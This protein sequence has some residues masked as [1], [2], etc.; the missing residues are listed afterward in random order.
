MPFYENEEDYLQALER[1]DEAFLKMYQQPDP[2][3][4]PVEKPESEPSAG[5]QSEQ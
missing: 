5:D 1:G 4:K 2:A 3:S